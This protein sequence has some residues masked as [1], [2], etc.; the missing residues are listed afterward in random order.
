[1]KLIRKISLFLAG[2]ILLLH[3][4]LPH[5][6]HSELSGKEHC[7]QHE[8]AANLVD[9]IKLVFHMDQGEGHLEKYQTS[10]QASFLFH[11]ILVEELLPD[12]ETIVSSEND[13]PNPFIQNSLH[14]RLLS[15]QLRFRG[16]P[17][18]V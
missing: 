13:F 15:S 8:T 2:S 12:F 16:P 6:H 1:M 14:S 17:H 9:F 10:G 18:W 7:E 4:V 11:A 5:E 3:T